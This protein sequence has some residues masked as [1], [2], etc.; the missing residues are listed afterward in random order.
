MPSMMSSKPAAAG[1]SDLG[2]GGRTALVL[3]FICLFTHDLRKKQ[4]RW[5]DGRLR[6]H[7][8]NKRVMVYDDRGNFVGDLHWTREEEFGEGEE[9]QL[10]RGTAIVQVLDCVGRKEQDLSELLDKRAKEKEQR[11]ARLMARRS[12]AAPSPNTPMAGS[13]AQD[14]FQTRHRPL[15]HLLGTPTGH[16]GR[17][18]VPSESPF[19]LRQRAS[20]SANDSPDT[21]PSKR[22]KREITPPVKKKGY[23]QNLFGA[24]LSLS[25]VPISSAPRQPA[26]SIYRQRSETPAQENLGQGAEQDIRDEIRQI[27]RPTIGS[28]DSS[29]KASINPSSLTTA[30]TVAERTSEEPGENRTRGLNHVE[31]RT[32]GPSRVEK[33]VPGPQRRTIE[34]VEPSDQPSTS[35]DNCRPSAGALRPIEELSRGKSEETA[36]ASSHVFETSCH[37]TSSI[38]AQAIGVSELGVSCSQAIVLDEDPGNGPDFGHTFLE[39]Q[40]T[41]SKATTPLSGTPENGKRFSKRDRVPRTTAKSP[42]VEP[43][44]LEQ[45]PTDAQRLAEERTELRLKPRKKRGLL[46]LSEKKNK[47]KQLR[48]QGAPADKSKPTGKSLDQ[49]PRSDAVEPSFVVTPENADASLLAQQD[50][51]YTESPVVSETHSGEPDHLPQQAEIHQ[52]SRPEEQVG[53]TLNRSMPRPKVTPPNEPPKTAMN[54]ADSPNTQ[55]GDNIA[56]NVTSESLPSPPSRK[57]RPGGSHS[58]QS[59]REPDDSEV[60]GQEESASEPIR[61]LPTLR[62]SRQTRK[63][64][65][66]DDIG[67]N[68]PK[69]KARIVDSDDSV[70]ELSQARDKPRLAKFSKK[71]VKSREIFGLVPSSS[72]PAILANT[73]RAFVAVGGPRESSPVLNERATPLQE[74]RSCSPPTDSAASIPPAVQKHNLVS[75]SRAEA[76]TFAVSQREEATATVMPQSDPLIRPSVAR[77]ASNSSPRQSGEDKSMVAQAF[78][79]GHDSIAAAKEASPPATT[80]PQSAI[81]ERSTT[82][83]SSTL[84]ARSN[85][86]QSRLPKQPQPP[87]SNAPNIG[88]NLGATKSCEKPHLDSPTAAPTRPR[89]A[90]PAT[91]GRKAALHSDAAGQV[92]RPILPAEPACPAHASGM[93]PLHAL[94]E[95]AAPR[96]S[97]RPKRQMRY[98][99]FTSAKGGGP[100]SREAHDLLESARPG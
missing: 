68:R 34:S 84:R 57:A 77:S 78:S 90:N 25:A 88:F 48:P 53:S 79:S 1:S 92:P 45:D 98:P 5:E 50:S 47:P 94:S 91:R 39:P 32:S 59:H 4:K 40:Q 13:R 86:E 11:Q 3:E 89:I 12:L 30:L 8:F 2:C 99:G 73:V 17:A 81:Q 43:K 23:A 35:F 27:E 82:A 80:R 7:T 74:P 70:E 14:H 20:S 28:R 76:Q 60:S 24:T 16:Y 46:V 95:P 66:L 75:D 51:T 21:R 36:R 71:S 6:Y 38:K 26:N 85:N 52:G 42:V 55:N 100:W 64:R 69:K 49:S 63:S 61:Q 44:T 56:E 31:S 15:N 72:P 10:D 96:D 62:S 41:V 33:L 83:S 97:E 58:K 67:S 19:E 54:S 93:Q 37:A 9:V 18:V 29:D 65:N 22:T 87:I